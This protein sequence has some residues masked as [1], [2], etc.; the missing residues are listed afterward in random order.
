[1]YVCMY[2]RTYV[3]MYVRM[4]VCSVYKEHPWH[5]LNI[6]TKDHKFWR[7]KTHLYSQHSSKPGHIPVILVHGLYKII[8]ESIKLIFDVKQLGQLV[9]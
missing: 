8:S 5:C 6:K 3:C 4:Y 9:I 2:V 7:F 1:M